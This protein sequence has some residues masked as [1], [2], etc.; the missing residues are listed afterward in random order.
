MLNCDLDL[1]LK[2]KFEDKE[3]KSIKKSVSDK[4]CKLSISRET[5]GLCKRK[6]R[7]KK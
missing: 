4:H 6:K 7:K 2:K 1:Q 5:A 3:Q